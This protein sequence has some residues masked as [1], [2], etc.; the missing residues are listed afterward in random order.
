M[1]K[2]EEEKKQKKWKICNILYLCQ[3]QRNLNNA[4][5]ICWSFQTTIILLW[6]YLKII[7][8]IWPLPSQ[9]R[10]T[11]K[12]NETPNFTKYCSL[13]PISLINA[14]EMLNKYWN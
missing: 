14:K 9:Y 1:Q 8:V 3:Y 7:I 2:Y 6:W 5:Y 13:K 12:F 4:G 11:V 10:W